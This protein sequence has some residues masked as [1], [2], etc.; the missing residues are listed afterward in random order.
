MRVRLKTATFQAYSCPD[1][2]YPW[3]VIIDGDTL[4]FTEAEFAEHCEVV[5]ET[6]N[7]KEVQA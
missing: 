5:P 4:C 6:E 2:K 3:K 7:E 1:P